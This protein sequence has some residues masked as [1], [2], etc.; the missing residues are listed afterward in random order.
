M[1][2]LVY[3]VFLVLLSSQV[4]TFQHKYNNP[5]IHYLVVRSFGLRLYLGLGWVESLHGEVRTFCCR[6]TTVWRR[7]RRV[8]AMIPLIDVA[9]LAQKESAP[10]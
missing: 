1:Y 5:C 7:R 8:W 10:F 6:G 2:D 3:H 4:N 9:Y